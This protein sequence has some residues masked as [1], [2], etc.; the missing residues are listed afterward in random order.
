MRASF[1]AMI[2][3]SISQLE[4]VLRHLKHNLHLK[5][6]RRLKH[7]FVQKDTE[8]EVVAQ[9]HNEVAEYLSRDHDAF[10][11]EYQ[12]VYDKAMRYYAENE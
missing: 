9:Y 4:D 6:N 3:N 2:Y 8:Y 10:K 5:H 11:A 12:K 1:Y 7:K